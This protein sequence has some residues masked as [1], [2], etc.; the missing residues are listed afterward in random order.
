LPDFTIQSGTAD[1]VVYTFPNLVIPFADSG[2]D[3]CECHLGRGDIMTAES[4][5]RASDPGE[6]QPE[7]DVDALRVGLLVSRLVSFN[8]R[9]LLRRGGLCI[10]VEY[11]TARRDELTR[12]EYMRVAFEEGSLDIAVDG[13][14]P[15]SWFRVLAS[16]FFRSRVMEDVYQQTADEHDRSGGY[17]V[18]TLRAL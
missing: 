12:T 10:R 18:T 15:W 2:S 1:L 13:Y 5:A 11:A 17:V 7:Q 6:A 8:L 9:S 4:L 14:L 16:S 3:L